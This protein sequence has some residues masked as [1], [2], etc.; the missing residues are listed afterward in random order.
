MSEEQSEKK[1]EIIKNERNEEVVSETKKIIAEMVQSEFSGPIP[2]PEIIGGYEKIV[3]GS[4]E[5]IIAMAERQ[6]AHRQEMERRM[7]SAESRDSLLGIIC[8]FLLGGICIV[9]A[10]II[11]INVPQSAG[12]ISSAVLGVTG[13]GSIVT[14]FVK[15]TRNSSKKPND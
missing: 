13:I 14:A 12:A 8:A 9:A 15:N 3:P 5:R 4:A 2:P 7:I 6:A 10:I 1:Q 11:V